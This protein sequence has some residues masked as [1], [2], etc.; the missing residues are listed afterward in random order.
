VQKVWAELPNHKLS[1]VGDYLGIE[2]E[3]HRASEDAEVCG[4]ISLKIADDLGVNCITEIPKHIGMSM[5]MVYQGGYEPC[6]CRGNGG[7]KRR[8]YR[9]RK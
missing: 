8:P 3:H 2:F 4:K 7:R 5:G 6:S 1:T 9:L